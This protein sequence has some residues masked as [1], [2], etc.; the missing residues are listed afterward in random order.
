MLWLF[1]CS[2]CDTHMNG[3][4]QQSEK[5]TKIVI[6][7]TS[8][9]WLWCHGRKCHGRFYGCSI[10][11]PWSLDN[12][13]WKV[14]ARV[15]P[16][17]SAVYDVLLYIVTARMSEREWWFM[18]SS[19]MRLSYMKK[20][21]KK[22][23]RRWGFMHFHNLCTETVIAHW[24]S[25]NPRCPFHSL[26]RY[27]FSPSE[28]IELNQLGIARIPRR[29]E[30]HIRCEQMIGDPRATGEPHTINKGNQ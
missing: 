9:D 12:A 8:C 7:R 17:H 1:V 19:F 25:S 10:C 28:L 15:W 11:D 26:S 27:L 14:F 4:E 22:N 6:F 3:D 29:E 16:C 13:I 18:S 5:K 24:S 23:V 20:Q 21:K 30:R 2:A